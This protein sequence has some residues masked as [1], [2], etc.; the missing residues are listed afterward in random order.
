MNS[1]ATATLLR[2]FLTSLAILATS[3]LYAIIPINGS[4]ASHIAFGN[5]EPFRSVGAVNL[6][7]GFTFGSGSYLG[8]GWVLTAAHVIEDVPLEDITFVI[9]GRTISVAEVFLSPDYVEGLVEGDIALLHL[10]TSDPD[11]TGLAG[12]GAV[13][14]PLVEISASQLP[15]LV[16][17]DVVI[18]GFGQNTVNGPDNA[19]TRR[20]ARSPVTLINAGSIECSGT[21]SNLPGACAAGDSGGAVIVNLFGID[22]LLAVISAVSPDTNPADVINLAAM[23]GDARSFIQTTTNSE[24][25]FT[26]IDTALP[27]FYDNAAVFAAATSTLIPAGTEDFDSAVYPPEDSGGTVADPLAPGIPNGAMPAGTNPAT[28]LT[29]Q[30]NT[31]GTAAGTS[32][33]PRGSDG[34]FI[35]APLPGVLTSELLL[36]Q[37]PRDSLDL[38]FSL[39]NKDIT[40]VSFNPGYFAG[41]DDPVP[42]RA[43]VFGNSGLIGD[44]TLQGVKT[45]NDGSFLGFVA[46]A[47]ESITRINLSTTDTSSV[48][49]VDNVTVFA[50]G[51]GRVD[52]GFD[53]IVSGNSVSA[54]AVQP[55]GK[56]IVVGDFTSIGGQT[57][58]RIARLNADGSLE[59]AATFNPGT[60]ADAIIDS[61]LVQPDGKIVI[62]GNFTTIDGQPRE[63]IARLNA[64][65]SLEGVATFNVSVDGP[66]RALASQPDGSLLVG[67]TFTSVNGQPRSKLAR[68]SATGVLDAAFT[69]SADQS[70]LGIALQPDEKIVIYG[71]FTSV[72]GQTR[73][74]IARLN[75]DG[76]VESTA[77]F[78]PGTGADNTVGCVV[79][80][81]DGKLLLGG[82]FTSIDGQP[83][84]FLAR[85]HGDGTLESTATFNPDTGPNNPLLSMVQ[86]TDGK[87]IIGGSFTTVNG[88]T[89][90][91]IARLNANGSLEGTTN[92]D[93]G[94]G[95]D[96]VVQSLAIQA[97]GG[98]LMGGFFTSVDGLARQHLARLDN[99]PAPQSF[100]IPTTRDQVRWTRGGAGP[101]LSQVTFEVST[102]GGTTWAHLGSGTRITGG[103]EKTGLSLPASGLIRARGRTSGGGQNGS[104]G[105][106]EASAPFLFNPEIV[107]TQ[108]SQGIEM[109]DGGTARTMSAV[110]GGS[111]SVTYVIENTGAADLILSGVPKI[112]LDGP[113]AADFIITQQPVSPIA[114]G[115]STTFTVQFT[116]ASPGHKTATLHIANNDLDEAT[117]DL[118]LSAAALALDAGFNVGGIDGSVAITLV[119]P[120]GKVLIAGNF[121]NVSG[122]PRPRI[123]RLLADGSPEGLSTF[124]PGTGANGTIACAALQPDGKILIGGRFT[125]VNGQ[126]RSRIARLNADGSLE[127]IATFDIG[128]GVNG[129]VQ[130]L[131]LQEDGKILIAGSFTSVN[132]QPR[133]SIARLNPDGSVEDTATFDPGTGPE[134]E[135]TCLALLADGRIMAGGNFATFNGLTRANLV[136]LNSDGSVSTSFNAPV[137]EDVVVFCIAITSNGR[138]AFG[139]VDQGQTGAVLGRVSATGSSIGFNQSLTG[140][141]ISSILLQTDGKLLIGGSFEVDDGELRRNIA[142]YNED[143]S[144]ESA[145]TFNTGGGTDGLV[146][147][148][149]QQA[150][151]KI[152]IGGGFTTLGG[153]A[154][155]NLARLTSDPATQNLTVVSADH[156]RWLRGGSSPEVVRVTFDLSINNGLTWAP[157]GAG[158]RITGGWELTGLT[159]PV[160]GQIRAQARTTGGFSNGSSGLMETITAFGP[161][162]NLFFSSQSSFDAQLAPLPVHLMGAEDFE[163]ANQL[164]GSMNDP[165]SPGVGNVAMPAGTK[166]AL[167]ITAQSH[168]L[169]AA[170]GTTLS[171]SGANAL[172][173]A[174]PFNISGSSFTSKFL[175]LNDSTHSLDLLFNLPGQTIAA[176]GLNPNLSDNSFQGSGPLTARVYG[177]SGMLGTFTLPDCGATNT[178][179]FIGYVAAEGEVITRINLST[180]SPG[181]FIGVDN[182]TV[183]TRELAPPLLSWKALHFGTTENTGDTADTGDFDD[184]GIPNLLEFAFATNPTNGNS[185]SLSVNGGVITQHGQPVPIYDTSDQ[186]F[187]ALF[188]RRLNHIA[189]GLT[190]TVQFSANLRDWED[191]T[192]TLTSTHSDGEVEIISVPFPHLLL[193]GL[194]PTFFRVLVNIVP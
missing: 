142:R 2:A 186:R 3:A 126:P 123:A 128:S 98:I 34:L 127:D 187:H 174:T 88:K 31:L 175:T 150:D 192:G 53:P 39:P 109:T 141:F 99:Q 16:G 153:A 35:F 113:S 95:A 44:F 105:I 108:Q 166:S 184:D 63:R 160:S 118:T 190:Y 17:T 91:R 59:S 120:D 96:N 29:V 147:S 13:G 92:F 134:G 136:R 11:F 140:D 117:F 79:V 185:G 85:L 179:S 144:L 32:L 170:A 1:Q 110:L 182:I 168:T 64:D 119:Q 148:L 164:G 25:T 167:G 6:T 173:L 172:F 23:T 169:G 122:Q 19:G 171:P 55:D 7:G 87:I 177:A 155:S 125:T 161:P 133:N 52:V 77:T 138:I 12:T 176:V 116:A 193:S 130:A 159:L 66:V 51:G 47:G 8:S 178:G 5:T 74:R 146:L 89:R 165:L 183:S 149:A 43:R 18:S 61:V 82:D 162:G 76:S 60:G 4:D 194:Q 69:P 75:S 78:N 114:P 154:R 115:G 102:D 189:A 41:V 54:T 131:A 135:I 100:T 106:V 81:P 97:D 93:P 37:Q 129:D 27:P 191:Y 56:I 38:R 180:T 112:T 46:P 104:S 83:K 40:A 67:G 30:S 28:G 139:G 58:N 71:S 10:D 145:T 163:S 57:R 70:V 68:I 121:T 45:S 132:G 48:L 14:L 181:L 86:Q 22:Y 84:N 73:N 49:C 157:L 20:A 15:A 94:V 36:V 103:W 152:L 9:N 80:Q 90:N 21:S 158:T 137:V 188:L 143:G 26:L 72:N 33:S 62:A 156:V 107:V 24:V 151:G 50:G 111:T 101:E 65:G 42:V 124:N